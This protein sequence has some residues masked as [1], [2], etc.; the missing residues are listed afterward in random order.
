MQDI[1]SH[2]N[3]LT[4]CGAMTEQSAAPRQEARNASAA[5]KSI[6]LTHKRAYANG[7]K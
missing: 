5:E 3:D 7:V 1:E 6:K 2:S 4:R